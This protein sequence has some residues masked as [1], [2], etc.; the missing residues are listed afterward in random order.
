M[1]DLHWWQTGVI[2]QVYP[3]SFQDASG[4]GVGDLRGITQ[5]LP[6]LSATLG[7]DALWISPFYPS[8]MADFGYD[9]ADYMDIDPLFGD[10]ADFNAL[11]AEAHRLDLKVI[12]DW[13][14]N[15][16]SDQ[17]PWFRAARASRDN[18]QRD[19]YIWRDAKPDGSPPNNWLAKFGGPAWTWDATTGQYYLHSYLPQQPD[20]NWRHP[21]V[22][23]AMFETLRFWLHR[24][25]DGFRIDVAHLILKDP[26]LRDNPPNP[27]PGSPSQKP[28]GAYDTQLHVYD[29]AHPD[30]HT[31]YRGVRR[32][33]ETYEARDGR[34]R[35]AIGEIRLVDLPLW[36]S[37]YG[38]DL[39][40][41]HLPC[42]FGLL[43]ARWTAR[44]LRAAVDRLEAALP[45]GAWPNY[46]LGNHD[47]PRIA[48]RSGPA[49]ARVATML[50]LTLRG[51]PILY[52]GDELGM[53]DVPIPPGLERDPFGRR[54]PGLQLG[55][56]PERTPMP[57]D[58]GPRAGF[59]PADIEPWLP[60]G[61]D[62]ATVNVAVQLADPVSPLA[63]TR[64]LLQ[65]RRGSEA[66]R[67]GGYHPLDGVPDGCFA[68][69]RE[70]RGEHLLVA[71]NFTG[72][73]QT[74]QLSRDVLKAGR[75]VVVLSTW[76]DRERQVVGEATGAFVL[77]TDEGCVLSL[78]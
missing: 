6:Y 14:P 66:L 16:T 9:V 71:L 5:R 36:A 73:A 43:H 64:R 40:E 4:D 19:W 49:Q 48:T 22:R 77:R 47:E 68:Y 54:V 52:Y 26:D 34:P 33:L 62:Y 30:T 72:Q 46:V 8:P 1:T 78:S 20:L 53:C 42:N 15:H 57:W 59:C 60:L 39:D 65:L 31:I 44:D 7:V 24:G 74:L 2:Y 32:L 38:A 11:I 51:T 35:V 56:D 21:D 61:E 69:L 75:A 41:L 28:L 10:L 12:I 45:A 70:A 37:Y 23:A 18:P 29:N 58:A 55:R 17:H 25:V 50:L 13:V 67:I 63:L 27:V 3:R 76:L